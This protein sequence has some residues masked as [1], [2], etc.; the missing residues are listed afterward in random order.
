[1][2]EA[3]K[4]PDQSSSEHGQETVYLAH[5]REE[6]Q[7]ADMEDIARR[8][9]CFMCPESIPEFYEERGGFIS[10]GEHSY[11]VF[12]GYPYENTQ[13]HIMAIP[14]EHVTKLEDV[15]IEFWQEALSFFQGLEK[16]LGITGG[17]IAMRFGNPAETGATAHHLHIHF[18]VPSKDI[19]PD[20]KPVRFRMSPSFKDH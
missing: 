12:N 13:Q 20:D 5:A 16:E 18:I 6:D 9:I 8:G 15:S 10:E 7:L 1:M 2:N 19:G 3:H 4:P 11:L 14:K 17:S